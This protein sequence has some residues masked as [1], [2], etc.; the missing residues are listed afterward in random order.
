MFVV[1]CWFCLLRVCCLLCVVGC[2]LLRVVCRLLVWFVCVRCRLLCSLFVVRGLSCVVVFF[3]V[4]GCLLFV[5]SV[6][7]VVCGS[8]S[9]VLLF[10]VCC[11]WCIVVRCCLL[12]VV[13][14]VRC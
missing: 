12:F 3:A 5:R 11:L 6:S 10:V 13:V 4:A 2:C 8:S 9:V 14:V 7:F 1:D